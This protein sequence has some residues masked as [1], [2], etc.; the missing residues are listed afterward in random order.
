VKDNNLAAMPAD[1][2]WALY[3]KIRAI[4]SSK[5]NAEMDEIE[6]RLAQLNGHSDKPNNRRAK[7]HRRPYP[8]VLPKYQNPER[9]FETWSGRGRQP[10]WIVT[11]LR[12]GRSPDDLLIARRH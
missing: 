8:K 2:L 5:L 6:R 11:Q 3:K 9:P 1:D 7:S 12:A 4:L 10:H